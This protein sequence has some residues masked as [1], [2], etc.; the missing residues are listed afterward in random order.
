[1]LFKITGKYGMKIL[2]I[3]LLFFNVMTA[4]SQSNVI[5]IR[6]YNLKPGTRGYFHRLFLEQCLPMLAR[7][8]VKVLGYGPSL[9]DTDSYF[10]MRGFNS[11][12]DREKA[13]DAFYGSEEWKTGPRE[14]VLAQIIS[15]TTIVLPADAVGVLAARSGDGGIS[16]SGR[17]LSDSA[18]LSALNKQF[19]RNFLQQDVAAH[20]EIIHPNFVCIE[21]DGSI[22]NRE[23]YLKNWASDY[24]HSGYQSFDYTDESIRIFHDMALV[25]AKTVYTKS[26]GGKMVKGFTVYTDTYVKEHGQWKCV[27]AQITP[28]K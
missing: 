10:L 18:R 16:A 27:Q 2:A 26:V 24:D 20:N 7:W 11:V 25:R 8:K 19:I 12:E 4:T 3:L 5:E 28:V 21:S 23:E 14:A 22:V 15:Y 1:M 6:S 17:T 13:E 9:H